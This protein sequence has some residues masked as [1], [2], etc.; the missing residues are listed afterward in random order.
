[1]TF[2]FQDTH[3]RKI[4]Y[5]IKQSILGHLVVSIGFRSRLRP[6]QGRRQCARR[7]SLEHAVSCWH[8]P[9]LQV[10]EVLPRYLHQSWN[11]LHKRAPSGVPTRK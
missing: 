5:A 2:S 4:A 6:F 8:R 9:S 7:R 11:K 1:M 3:H 10:L